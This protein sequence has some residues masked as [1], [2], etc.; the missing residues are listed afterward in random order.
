MR[1][2]LQAG[3]LWWGRKD[4]RLLGVR[5]IALVEKEEQD[6][7]YPRKAAAMIKPADMKPATQEKEPAAYNSLFHKCQILFHSLD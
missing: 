6:S 4:R 7:S 2:G 1:S 3:S 5:G